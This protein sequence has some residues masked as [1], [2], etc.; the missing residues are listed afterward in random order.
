[1]RNYPEGKEDILKII[2]VN[3]I[4]GELLSVGGY[5]RLLVL[6]FLLGD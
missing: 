5:F 4:G 1:M 2:G 6:H 3:K